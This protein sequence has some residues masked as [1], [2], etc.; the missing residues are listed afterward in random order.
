MGEAPKTGT[1]PVFI[2]SLAYFQNF[3]NELAPSKMT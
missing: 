2:A 3:K 1:S